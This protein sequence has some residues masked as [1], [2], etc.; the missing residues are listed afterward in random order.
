MVDS[1]EGSA[2]LP[3]AQGVGG[4][5]SALFP[6]SVLSSDAALASAAAVSASQSLAVS[7]ENAAA[8]WSALTPLLAGR[9]VVRE[10]R[11]GGRSYRARWQ[12]PLTGRVPVSVPAAVPIYSSA[13]DTRFLVV[14]LDASLGGPAQVRRDAA[15]VRELVRRAGG[16]L[17]S[18]ESPSGGMHLYIPFAEPLGFYQARDLARALAARTPSM[19]V[20]PN[21]GLTDG[22]IRPPGARHRSGGFQV[23]HGSLGVAVAL[24]R[25]GNP[26]SVWRNLQLAL[27][28]ELAAATP[29]ADAAAVDTDAGGAGADGVGGEGFVARRGGPRELAV[30]YLRIATAGIYDTGRYRTPSEARQAVLTAAVW[31]GHT[32]TFVL[33]RMHT[34]RW[35][36]FQAFYTRYRTPAARRQALLR[37]WRTAVALVT[38]AKAKPSTSSLVRQSPTSR[39]D[40]HRGVTGTAQTNKNTHAE[41]QF[42]RTWHN[43]LLITENDDTHTGGWLTRRMV[44]RAIGE[45]AFKSGSRFVH[46][47]T[48]SLSVGV[49]VDH[50]TVAAHLRALRSGPDALIDL[51]QDSRGGDGDLYELVIPTRYA[52]RAGRR[53]WRGGKLHALRPVF[54][55][56][57]APAALV[58]EVLE[59]A[60]NPL[61]SFDLTNATGL[62]RSAV[63]EAL[64]TL[65]AFDLARQ[66]GG[67]WTV[68]AGTDLTVLAEQ[69]GVLE[70]IADQVQR[71]RVE[72]AAYRRVLHIADRHTITADPPSWRVEEPESPPDQAIETALDVLQ[73]IL[74]A[75][76]IPA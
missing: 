59:H 40:T 64:E 33:G 71:H 18:D 9:P 42:L 62:S 73:R 43:A 57:G 45:A 34:G 32:L 65:G 50:T 28:A 21:C 63:Y 15:A 30:D 4:G 19:D 61:R 60:R 6:K 46:F 5:V 76:P 49:G 51:I 68:V 69:L 25:A 54:L 56:L 1:S 72:R 70:T 31:A 29:G 12:R 10:S 13:G 16:E 75:Y 2:Y 26:P 20:A 37:D 8:V 27:A 53:D 17:F 14:D 23:L 22:L 58:Y 67:R 44:L 11:D 48:R 66:R 52:G 39:P 35:P 47:G 7:A 55:E 74:G 24:A 38:A 3:A 36:G 41:F